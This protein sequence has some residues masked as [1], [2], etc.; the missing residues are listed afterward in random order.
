VNRQAVKFVDTHN[1]HR[2][3]VITKKIRAA[4]VYFAELPFWIWLASAHLTV[5]FVSRFIF[6]IDTQ[7]HQFPERAIGPA[8]LAGVDATQR[9]PIF[10]A[11]I[12]LSLLQFFIVAGAFAGVWRWV[13]DHTRAIHSRSIDAI[14]LP[15]FGISL[16]MSATNAICLRSPGVSPCWPFASGGVI[17]ATYATV[18]FVSEWSN[19]TR[20]RIIRASIPMSLVAIC[21]LIPYFFTFAMASARGTPVT[22]VAHQS[23]VFFALSLLLWITVALL[24]WLALI[25]FIPKFCATP[26]DARSFA[27]RLELASSPF[28]LIPFAPIVASEIAYTLAGLREK[29]TGG[30]SSIAAALT[31]AALVLAA[32]MYLAF[33]WL[34]QRFALRL[35]TFCKRLPSYF[36]APSVIV[37][38]YLYSSWLP[39]THWNS[40]DFL[41][42]GNIVVPAEQLFDFHKLPFVDIW[43]A[44][45]LQ[46]LLPGVLYRLLHGGA[47]PLDAY[48]W[49]QPINGTISVLLTYFILRRFVSSWA[50]TLISLFTPIILIA[51]ESYYD[52]ALIGGLTL[53]WVAQ[54]PTTRRLLGLWAIALLSFIWMPSIA[55]GTIP[56]LALLSL[57]FVAVDPRWRLWR[58]VMTF[59]VI[60]GVAFAIFIALVH[61]RGHS[62][63]QTLALVSVFSQYDKLI[64]SYPNLYGSQAAQI[65]VTQYAILPLVG[66]VG[67][68]LGIWRL[69][70][71][72]PREPQLIL[73]S[74]LSAAGLGLFVRAYY[75]HSLLE[76]FQTSFLLFVAFVL[77][78]FLFRRK[79]HG[80]L[81]G[82][83][84]A[85]AFATLVIAPQATPIKDGPWFEFINWSPHQPRI[86]ESS[87][88]E[89]RIAD[90]KNFFDQNL[91]PNQT[92]AEI[93]SAHLLYPLMHRPFPF[94]HHSMQLIQSEAPQRI[95]VQ[96][97][98]AALAADQIPFVIVDSQE[99][100]GAKIDDIPSTMSL[101]LISEFIYR[102]YEPYIRIHDFDIWRRRVLPQE[103]NALV[104]NSA[105]HAIP[106]KVPLASSG[107]ALNDATLDAGK[108]ISVT[109]GDSDPQFANFAD[110]KQLHLSCKEHQC[111]A[112]RFRYE[113]N[114][115]GT[116]QIFY[117]TAGS[118]FSE[119]SSRMFPV[120]NKHEA[121]TPWMSL[122][123]RDTQLQDMRIDPPNSSRFNLLA[124]E[125]EWRSSSAF[126]I[127][128]NY[129][130]KKLPFIWGSFDSRNAATSTP[131]LASALSHE[132]TLAHDQS[133]K[134][135]I[136]NG[137]RKQAG[138]YL[139]FRLGSSTEGAVTVTISGDSSDEIGTATF[140]VV[141]GAAPK[142]YLIRVSSFWAWYAA[143]PQPA[144]TLTNNGPSP[145][146]VVSVLVRESD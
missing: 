7:A 110:W 67:L 65:V 90:L 58:V 41:H 9:T 19:D 42:T 118:E 72:A 93:I 76:H 2:V 117:R 140:D 132:V 45:G 144:I 28:F 87:D 16:F 124:A 126:P 85:L 74:Y 51:L 26:D 146:N 63:S 8:I 60:F 141:G 25:F 121:W 38:A 23:P 61:F 33:P 39:T 135:S 14:L 34:H 31:A 84:V 56:S 96:Q 6:S 49:Y 86:V 101:Y 99:W 79:L 32:S 48:L 114:N 82:S 77:P 131:L 81:C 83:L 98:Q 78:L 44:R 35:T 24:L 4:R 97:W 43:Y 137:M 138:N 46:D 106:T 71:R 80:L 10:M 105:D 18:V 30:G 95:Y 123:L 75:R 17:F 12:A 139:D 120:T 15:T 145:L 36:W 133:V 136:A 108:T 88:Q 89:L 112:V 37:T 142:D 21:G 69:L 55:L 111:P 113:N 130:M 70:Q 104:N 119:P 5:V 134:M 27:R 11:V 102:N 143:S 3:D 103:T 20:S 92:F 129:P 57:V 122:D 66:V 54:R 127:D 50:A 73:L 64:G 40:Y 59:A 107:F 1:Q 125:M 68:S 128:Q 53:I 116:M 52:F 62:I 100:W 91:K 94:F 13:K 115:S 29:Q 109:T 22:L 47:H